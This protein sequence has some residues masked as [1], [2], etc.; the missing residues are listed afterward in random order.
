MKKIAE[1]RE[2]QKVLF[3]SQGVNVLAS[4]PSNDDTEDIVGSIYEA[5]FEETVEDGF[6]YDYQFTLAGKFKVDGDDEKPELEGNYQ[7]FTG[8]NAIVLVKLD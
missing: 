1:V 5:N 3:E 6:E 4:F 7:V 2:M 8:M